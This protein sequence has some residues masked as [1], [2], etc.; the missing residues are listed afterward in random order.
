MSVAHVQQPA[1][2]HRHV[3]TL[4]VNQL[5]FAKSRSASTSR[6]VDS[7]SITPP[8]GATDSI[9]CAMPTCSPTAV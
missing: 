8:G 5:R 4:D 7:L 3:D 1:G 6:A 9:R 2:G